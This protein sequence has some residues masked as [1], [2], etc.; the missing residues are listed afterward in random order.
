MYTINSQLL[1]ALITV[2]TLAISAPGVALADHCKGKHRNDP[3][4]GGGGG[5]DGGGTSG[6]VYDVSPTV[7]VNMPP[8]TNPIYA[9]ASCD[10]VTPGNSGS[11]VNFT[12]LMPNSCGALT[13]SDGTTLLDDR[14]FEFETDRDG[15]PTAMRVIG[16]DI[17]GADGIAHET[18]FVPVTVEAPNGY[19]A[20]F[21]I[22]V[23]T[24]AITL[25]ELDTHRV[26]KKSNRVREAGDFALHDLIYTVQP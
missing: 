20:A 22:H 18:D 23:D 11:G 25:W 7:D 9:P 19:G 16:Q 12:V 24:N 5:D 13:T 10:G 3:G 1:P 26:M 4:C 21:V 15:N 6:L 2:V 8:T 14:I 17:V